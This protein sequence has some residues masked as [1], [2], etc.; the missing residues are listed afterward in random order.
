MRRI[1]AHKPRYFACLDAT[2]GFF[3]IA[4]DDA[5][6]DLLCF[7]TPRGNFVWNRAPMGPKTVPALYQRAMYVEAF[8]DMVTQFME[9]YLDDFIIWASTEDELVSRVQK[10]VDRLLS[11]NLKLNPNKCKFGL[12]EVEYCG[13]LVSATSVGFSS[14]RLQEVDAWSLPSTEGELKSFLGLAGYFQEHVPHFSELTT[15]Y[16][17]W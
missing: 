10:V 15:P 13:H 6:K 11:I 1:A 14:E 16:G 12:S 17:R 2:Q 8:H 3:Q 9:I 7:T 5:S 4:I